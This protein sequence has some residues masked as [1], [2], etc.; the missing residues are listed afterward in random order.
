MAVASRLAVGAVALIHVYF[1]ALESFL[2][3]TRGRKVFGLTKEKA[4]V[5]AAAMTNQACYNAFL[6]AALV[7]GQLAESAD[8]KHSMTL[9]GLGC[10]VAAGAVGGLT[11]G[12][13]VFI[14][15]AV[16]A[17]VALGLYLNGL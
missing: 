8:V 7:L 15:Q 11:I 16:P 14:F 5:L 17:I 10:V 2:F 4:E 13:R 9:Y 1:V 12:K 3:N 6:V